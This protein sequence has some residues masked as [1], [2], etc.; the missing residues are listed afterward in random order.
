M[1]GFFFRKC[2]ITPMCIASAG[3]SSSPS[4]KSSP[5]LCLLQN[6]LQ[7]KKENE[8]IM[9][10]KTNRIVRS[11]WVRLQYNSSL[12]TLE[13]TAIFYSGRITRLAGLTSLKINHTQAETQS[14]LMLPAQG[15]VMLCWGP[16]E[17]PWA[18]GGGYPCSC[19]CLGNWAKAGQFLLL[20][21]FCPIFLLELVFDTQCSGATLCFVLQRG[22]CT[23]ML[24]WWT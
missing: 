16:R 19:F 12:E 24:T 7:G 13:Q 22:C 14:S 6:C 17:P 23:V 1:L 3:Q 4:S 18:L 15:F 21:P 8:K 10:F 11:L 20:S 2:E 5:S 9:V